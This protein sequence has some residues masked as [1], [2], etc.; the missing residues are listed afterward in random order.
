MPN[1]LNYYSDLVGSGSKEPIPASA[2][3]QATLKQSTEVVVWSKQVGNDQLLW[4][5]NGPEQRDYAT[6]F[7]GLDLVASGNGSGNAGDDLDGEVVLTI[8]DSDQRRV[9]ASTTFDTLSQLRDALSESRSDRPVEAALAPYANP[10]R[11]L[12]VRIVADA[13]SDGAEIDPASSSG[14]L[15]YTRLSN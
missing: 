6:A 5:G 7:V 14:Q 15:Y 8:T 9:L 1:E 11:H 10:G 4:H 2:M 12:E 13:A 3:N